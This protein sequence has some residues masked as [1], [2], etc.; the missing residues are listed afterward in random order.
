MS[1][2]RLQSSDRVHPEVATAIERTR[3][4]LLGIQAEDGHWCGE[5]EGDTILESE[6]ILLRFFLGQGPDEKCR[7]AAEYIRRKQ[8]PEGGWSIY[9]GG[10]PEVS[11]SVKDYLVLKLL[12]DD[13]GA[14]HMRRAREAILRSGGLEA[15]N[16]FTKM[17]LAVAGQYDW[18]DCPAVPPEIILLPRWF[19]INIYEMSSWSRAI[20]VP[21]SI[22]W[23]HRP[24]RPLPSHADIAELSASAVPRRDG[25]VWSSLFHG[26]DRCVKLVEKSPLL[27]SRE[28]ALK[29]AEAWILERLEGSDGLGA[30]FP[31]IVNT[32]M[33]LRCLGYPE[34]HPTVLAQ[35]R[36]LEKLEIEEEE[37]LRV[38]PCFSAGWDTALAMNALSE[39]GLSPED[40]ALLRAAE[41]VL[42]RRGHGR[43][44][45]RHKSGSRLRPGWFF[46]YANPFYPD[47]DT[48]AMVI[49]ALSKVRF[50]D[51][52]ADARRRESLREAHEWHRSMQNRDGGWGAFDKNCDKEVLTQVPF[53]DHNAMIDPSNEDITARVLECFAG[54]GRDRRDPAVRRAVTYVLSRQQHDGSWFGR[55]GCNYIYGTF[56]CLWGLARIGE[57]P[58]APWGRRAMAWLR[59]CQNEDGGWGELPDSYTDPSRKGRGPSTP[60]Q[61]AWALM[62]LM[63]GGEAEDEA[64]E[65]G[66]AYLLERQRPEGSWEEEHWTGTGFPQV[67]YLRYH[68]YATYFPL[69]TLATYRKLARARDSETVLR[70]AGE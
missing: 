21:L 36:E 15:C 60:S 2:A 48:T 39:S 67:F 58:Q 40:P 70:A 8:L 57:D 13:P 22:I 6:Y 4:Y 11:A 54:L 45:W 12:G 66:V 62:G 50:P 18:A 35:I 17:Y 34:D 1:G 10:P 25:S 9:P 53:A 65:R 52:W 3:D 44:D 33:A 5:L 37:T 20:F 27:P 28:I 43:G 49:T 63:A 59:S 23:A 7:K 16:S 46:E 51:S 55:W 69:L 31:P 26:I 14:P 42:D 41:W 30:I 61:T 24:V 64:V 56:L 38:Q 19:T 47:N 68:L 32:I 29:R